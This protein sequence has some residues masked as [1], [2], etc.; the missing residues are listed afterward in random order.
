MQIFAPYQWSKQLTH[1][2]ELGKKLEEAKEEGN[3][4]RG[5]N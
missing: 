5:P 4:V 1:V 2:V 3:S